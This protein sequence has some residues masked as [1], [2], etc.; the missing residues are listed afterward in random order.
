MKNLKRR[1]PKSDNLVRENMEELGIDPSEALED[2]IQ[3]LTLQGVDLS[4]LVTCLPGHAQ[5]NP[6]IQCLNTF[7]HLL[8]VPTPH[9]NDV[10]QAVHTFHHLC[11]HFPPNTSIATKNDAVCLTSS[12]CS[13]IPFF[14]FALSAFSSLLHNL[15]I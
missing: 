7:T 14:V 1:I 2:T 3:T 9:Q 4:G 15:F 6:L 11:S 13:N 10:A 5:T 12:L 8:T